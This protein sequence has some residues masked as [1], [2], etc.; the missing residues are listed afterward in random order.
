ML[1]YLVL[2][3]NVPFLGLDVAFELD[4]SVFNT[5]IAPVFGRPLNPQAVS[6][7]E[8]ILSS[9]LSTLEFFW[10]KGNGRFLLGGNQASHP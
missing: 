3:V 9:S 7:A 10:L 1:G 2:H 5:T 6:E 8:M 4:D